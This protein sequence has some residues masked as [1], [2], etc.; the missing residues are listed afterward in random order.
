MYQ[1]TQHLIYMSLDTAAAPCLTRS[2]SEVTSGGDDFSFVDQGLSNA[3]C[4]GGG[5]G[6]GLPPPPLLQP[7]ASA[8]PPQQREESLASPDLSRAGP[9]SPPPCPD[10]DSTRS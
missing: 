9:K 1:N 10:L 8:S 5:S 3:T 2:G 6:T 4:S 7:R